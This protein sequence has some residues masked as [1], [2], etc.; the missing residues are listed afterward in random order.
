[1]V[2]EHGVALRVPSLVLSRLQLAAVLGMEG[3]GMR[4]V[5]L[6]LGKVGWDSW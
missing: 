3:A 2:V 1:M 5:T 4:T 6:M